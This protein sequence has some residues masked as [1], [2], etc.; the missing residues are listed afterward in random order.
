MRRIVTDGNDGLTKPIKD[1]LV[2]MY[3]IDQRHIRTISLNCEAGRMQMISLEMY[4]DPEF[5]SELIRARNEIEALRSE[6]RELRPLVDP[7]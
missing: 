7:E 5:S 4:V 2:H 6:L 3:G 1:Y